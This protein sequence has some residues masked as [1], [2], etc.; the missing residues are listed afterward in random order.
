[1]QAYNKLNAEQKKIID[2]HHELPALYGRYPLNNTDH[3]PEVYLNQRIKHQARNEQT[4]A[5]GF[6]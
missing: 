4:V 3:E 1:M 5:M 6:D 2:N